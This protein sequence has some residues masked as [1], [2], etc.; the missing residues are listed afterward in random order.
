MKWA[1]LNLEIKLL[2]SLAWLSRLVNEATIHASP[3]AA[4]AN[5]QG[6]SSFNPTLNPLQ[7][8]SHCDHITRITTAYLVMKSI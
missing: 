7:P 6:Q 8:L 1:F 4:E 2:C 5:P 3:N